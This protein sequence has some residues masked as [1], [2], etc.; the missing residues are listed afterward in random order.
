MKDYERQPAAIPLFG[1]PT[2]LAPLPAK[3]DLTAALG[4][5]LQQYNGMIEDAEAAHAAVLTEIRQDARTYA[6]F[7]QEANIPPMTAY[8]RTKVET[9]RNKRFGG[10]ETIIVPDYIEV[11]LWPILGDKNLDGFSTATKYRLER[12]PC[13]LRS[14]W[15]IVKEMRETKPGKVPQGRFISAYTTICVDSEGELV[16]TRTIMQPERGKLDDSLIEHT[17]PVIIA[18]NPRV[19]FTPPLEAK[20]YAEYAELFRQQ[21]LAT[22]EYELG[23]MEYAARSKRV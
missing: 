22:T 6:A 10:T 20:D 13:S 17:G 5:Q 23:Q 1:T 7:A 2:G 4:T 15:D 12:N 16:A 14:E 19:L 9:T 8:A 3:G 21:I 18:F 11:P